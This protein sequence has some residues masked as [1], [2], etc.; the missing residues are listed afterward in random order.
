MRKTILRTSLIAMLGF[1]A[2]G[3]D[4]MNV[5]AAEKTLSFVQQEKVNGLIR[6]FDLLDHSDQSKLIAILTERLSRGS[7]G[8]LSSTD[9]ISSGE[10]VLP[11]TMHEVSPHADTEVEKLKKL[12]KDCV[13][14]RDIETVMKKNATMCKIC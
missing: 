11:P 8:D 13:E 7:D 1:V 5:N 2:C 9:Q 4:F 10:K 14:K 3:N 6:G 12:I